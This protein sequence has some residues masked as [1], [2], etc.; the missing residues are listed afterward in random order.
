MKCPKC[1]SPMDVAESNVGLDIRKRF[2]ICSRFPDCDGK[3][4]RIRRKPP[5]KKLDDRS[6][7]ILEHRAKPSSG[8]SLIPHGFKLPAIMGIGFLLVVFVI[9]LTKDNDSG[10]VSGTENTRSTQI[11]TST[12]FFPSPKPIAIPS[13]QPSAVCRD[14]TYSYSRSRRG[15]CS[16]HGGVARWVTLATITT[17][18]ESTPI[19]G[20]VTKVIDGDTIDVLLESGIEDRIRLIGID[21]PETYIPNK[22]NEYGNITDLD[23]LTE[24]GDKATAFTGKHLDV[25]SSIVLKFDGEKRKDA[26][27]RL[28]AYVHLPGDVDFNK[29]LVKSGLARVYVEGDSARELDYLKFQ[30]SAVEAGIGLWQCASQ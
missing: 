5:Q 27:G 18:A 14:G 6:R 1:G 20:T 16:H 3:R 9:V 24:W 26:Y 13:P 19:S 28:L 21:T 17:P 30:V 4:D 8:R 2:L 23:C 7:I 25:G 15:T 29:E 10:T 12:T 11:T 22:Q